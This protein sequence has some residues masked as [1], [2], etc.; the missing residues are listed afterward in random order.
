MSSEDA[1]IAHFRRSAGN[2]LLFVKRK[3]LKHAESPVVYGAAGQR[4][5]RSR[6]TE[7]FM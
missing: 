4:G 7:D 3:L 5:R 2:L 1:N 6:L